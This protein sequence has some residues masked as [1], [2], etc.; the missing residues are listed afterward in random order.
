MTCF[1]V[2]FFRGHGD[3]HNSMLLTKLFA[4]YES[5][6][7]I[8]DGE[9]SLRTMSNLDNLHV[10][11]GNLCSKTQRLQLQS[12]MTGPHHY[13]G[14]LDPGKWY[15]IVT[16]QKDDDWMVFT[17][18]AKRPKIKSCLN[19]C[20]TIFTIALQPHVDFEWMAHTLASD[21]NKSLFASP[22]VFSLQK[23]LHIPC[24]DRP[25]EY[26]W[27]SFRA[28]LI[29]PNQS[30]GFNPESV[31]HFRAAQHKIRLVTYYYGQDYFD[32]FVVPNK[33]DFLEHHEFVQFI[34]ALDESSIGYI[35]LGRVALNR[36]LQLVKFQIPAGHTL[37][38]DSGCIHGDSRLVGLFLMGM[39]GN[40]DAMRTANTVFFRNHDVSKGYIESKKKTFDPLLTHATCDN[41][42]LFLKYKQVCKLIYKHVS[43]ERPLSSMLWQPALVDG[44]GLFRKT[45]NYKRWVEWQQRCGTKLFDSVLCGFV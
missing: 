43:I 40:H 39:T 37:V 44:F 41:R 35:I 12:S 21:P 14:Y 3:E 2:C 38:L 27:T 19:A 29:P 22:G 17:P 6:S 28:Q 31:Q 24:I 16:I 4:G 34:H 30:F 26:D 15:Q 13:Y 7:Q 5:V 9:Y 42:Q 8:W 23:G 45:Q 18:L 32:D 1:R 10:V 33:S 25:Q 11:R 20:P 36:E